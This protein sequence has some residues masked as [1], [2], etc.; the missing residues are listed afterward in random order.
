MPVKV[1]DMEAAFTAGLTVRFGAA[2]EVRL[3]RVS[4]IISSLFVF[5]A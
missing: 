1:E 4:W 2:L 3:N 5:E